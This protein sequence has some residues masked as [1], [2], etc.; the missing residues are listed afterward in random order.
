MSLGNRE[1][2]TATAL[3]IST[4]LSEGPTLHSLA[5]ETQEVTEPFKMEPI[6]LRC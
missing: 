3:S 5:K 2:G 1:E 6:L 4:V